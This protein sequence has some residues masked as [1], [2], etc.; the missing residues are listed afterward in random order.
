MLAALIRFRCPV[1]VCQ[2][3]ETS[4]TNLWDHFAHRRTGRGTGT[5]ILKAKLLNQLNA[6]REAVLQNIL[7][8]LQKAYDALDRE[9]CL[10]ILVVYGVG[11][12]TLRILWTYWTWL[13]MVAKDGR[14]FAP[15]PSR[16]NVGQPKAIMCIPQC[17]T[18]WWM[19]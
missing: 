14:Q 7:L 2:G 4:R 1:E 15:P 3:G 6:M 13:W 8:D 12:W 18:W 9:W 10:N 11:P 17:S 16:D 19:L 5:A